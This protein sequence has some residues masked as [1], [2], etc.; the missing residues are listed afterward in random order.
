MTATTGMTAA[1]LAFN[2]ALLS[3]PLTWIIVA[4]IAVIAIIY[5]VVAAINHVTGS[6]ISATGVI[7]GAFSVAGAFLYNLVI[8]LVNGIITM[9]IGLYNLISNFASGLILVFTHPIVA[10]EVMFMSLFNFILDI[11]KGAAQLLDTIFGSNLAGAVNDFQ[12]NIQ[13]KIDDKINAAGGVKPEQLN[14]SD[15]TLDRK[16]YSSAYSSG[17]NW[18]ANI[19]NGFNKDT[20]AAN[21]AAAAASN[22]ANTAN[23]AANTGTTAGNTGDTAANTAAIANSIDIS[24]EQLKYLRDIAER[25]TVNR[26]TTASIKVEMTNHNNINSNMDLDGI[27]NDLTGMID[28]AVNQ[29]AAGVHK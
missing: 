16:D 9:G 1:Q 15:Y 10:I 26:F 20:S 27:V 23:T 2:A 18:G 22:A 24:N 11:V 19:G 17:Y 6:S 25:D 29:T 4:I 28:D 12:L 7:C 3:C 14:A 5:L 21:S 13:A 8:G